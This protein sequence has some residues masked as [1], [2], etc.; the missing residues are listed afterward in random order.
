MSEWTDEEANDLM[1]EHTKL[2]DEIATLKA[3]IAELEERNYKLDGRYIKQLFHEK[4]YRKALEII[5]TNEECHCVDLYP[6]HCAKCIATEAL[7][8][9][10]L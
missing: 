10:E 9:G 4:R 3:H 8:E 6:E 7:K 1:K 5:S 2:M